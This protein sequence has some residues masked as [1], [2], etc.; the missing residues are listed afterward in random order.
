MRECYLEK[1]AKCRERIAVFEEDPSYRL[2]AGMVTGNQ[3]IEDAEWQ[4]A[5][6][7]IAI[8]RRKIV[9]YEGYAR[10]YA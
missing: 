3:R 4:N 7:L 8:E 2:I 5:Q 6:Q 9:E 10:L 1:I